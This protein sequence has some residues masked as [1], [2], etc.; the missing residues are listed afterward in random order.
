MKEL[1]GKAAIVTGA[2]RGLGESIALE[3][4][5][6]GVS[7]T[8]I[9]ILDAAGSAL[10]SQIN[11]RGWRAK[12]LSCDVT[13]AAAV[14]QA[15][16]EAEQNFGTTDILVNNAA[17]ALPP[18]PVAELSDDD[19]SR[20]LNVNV[21]GMLR[22]CRATFNAMRKAGGGSV[23]NLSSVHQSHSLAGWTAYAASKG[24]V[25]SVTRQLAAEWGAWNIRVNSVSPGAI[26]AQMTRDIL[27]R[28]ETGMLEQKFKHMHALERLGRP[29]EVAKTV[30]FL[31][32][33]GAAFITGEDILVDGGLTKL[34]RL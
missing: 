8:L 28:D 5:S 21:M 34:C 32:S 2:A 29:E 18:T 9:D 7:V 24:A 6:Q 10:E 4:A 15:V 20:V 26:D 17:I 30:A 3:L 1:S 11:A 25:I 22:F 31:A 33:D 23:I 14:N 13:S 27:E 16:A 12:Y 19:L